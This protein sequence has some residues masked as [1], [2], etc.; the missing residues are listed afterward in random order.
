MNGNVDLME[1]NVIQLNGGIMVNVDVIVKNVMY[2]KKD[3]I[4][5]PSATNC[6]NGNYLARIMD[7]SVIVCDEVLES[8]DE[9]TNF[10]EKKAIC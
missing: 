4:W 2:V 7:D 5:N 10:N 9:E 8:Y 1:E 6:K 3:Y